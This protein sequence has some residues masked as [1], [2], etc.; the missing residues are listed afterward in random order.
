MH[1]NA[2]S[3]RFFYL[4]ILVLVHYPQKLFS[5][6]KNR[7]D[8]VVV[9]MV[10]LDAIDRGCKPRLGQTKDYIIGICCFSAL[11]NK[12]KDWFSLNQYNKF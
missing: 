8:G 11:G 4:K 6:E 2:Y 7:I 12:R 9:G 3:F 10:S 1:N 5:K